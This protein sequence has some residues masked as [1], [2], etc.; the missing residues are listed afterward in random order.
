MLIRAERE[1]DRESIRAINMAAFESSA[2]ADLVDDLRQKARLIVSLVA[3]ENSEIVG[4]IMFSPVSLAGHPDLKLMGLGP[5]AVAPDCQ[6][7]GYGSALVQAGLDCCREMGVSAVV[8]LGHPNYYPRFGF[9]PS[10]QFGIDSE[11]DVPDEVFM[12]TELKP[13]CFDQIAGTVKYH[14]AFGGL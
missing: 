7:K 8:V 13:D 2:E 10:S 9:S 5:M 6:R 14:P 11:Y 1:A 3:Q 12:A 4:H